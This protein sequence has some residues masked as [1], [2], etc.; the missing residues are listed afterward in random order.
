MV[1]DASRDMLDMVRNF[2]A[3]FA[4]ESC[5]FCTPC[6]VGTPLL[7]DLVEKVARGHATEHDLGELR[8]IGATMRAMS[9]CGLGKTAPNAAFDVLEKF[10]R[11][12][13]GRL[14]GGDF[15]PGF[16]LD[17]ALSEARRLTG[18]DDPEAHL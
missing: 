8:T 17:A 15:Q 9:Q 11:A 3:F 1:F 7:R 10:P 14:A 16:D 4:H 12:F 13:R 18:R 2:T 6:R 5:G